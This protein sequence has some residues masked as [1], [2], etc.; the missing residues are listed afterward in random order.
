MRFADHAKAQPYLLLD[1]FK[2]FM[3]EATRRA[4]EV[5]FP[6]DHYDQSDF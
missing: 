2:E 5:S 1:A 6:K 4:L 3:G